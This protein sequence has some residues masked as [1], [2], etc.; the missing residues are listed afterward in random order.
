MTEG[1]RST[2]Q[3]ITARILGLAHN[4]FA[5]SSFGGGFIIILSPL[6]ISIHPSTPSNKKSSK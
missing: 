4:S 6:F 2:H 1:G 5:S 3:K